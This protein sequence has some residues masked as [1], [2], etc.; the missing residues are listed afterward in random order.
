MDDSGRHPLD[1]ERVEAV[2]GLL[3]DAW[4]SGEPVDEP[5]VISTCM[6]ALK[7]VKKAQ[8]VPKRSW[9]ARLLLTINVS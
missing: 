9:L 3:K 7:A 2:L 5:Y 8:Y 1:P 6:E 4:S